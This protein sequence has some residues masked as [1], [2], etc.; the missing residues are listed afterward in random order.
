MA[1]LGRPGPHQS[2]HTVPHFP[3]ITTHR[4]SPQVTS[5]HRCMVWT[6]STSTLRQLLR[7]QVSQEFIWSV[8]SKDND[9][10]INLQ[11]VLKRAEWGRSLYI[12]HFFGLFLMFWTFFDHSIWAIFHSGSFGSSDWKKSWKISFSKKVEFQG[13]LKLTYF[14]ISNFL[15]FCP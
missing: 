3:T 13:W 9:H 14:L 2:R 12:P 1:G 7:S 15:G 8:F 11:G 5:H 6:P 10:Q 4:H